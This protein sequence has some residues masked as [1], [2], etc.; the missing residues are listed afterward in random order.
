MRIAFRSGSHP[1]TNGLTLD[2][3]AIASAMLLVAGL[4]GMLR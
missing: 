3:L 2:L 4:W 1:I